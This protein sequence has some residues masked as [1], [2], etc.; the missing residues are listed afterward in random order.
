MKVLVTG[1][2]GFIG[3]HLVERLVQEGHQV[4]C[5]AK[6]RLHSVFLESLGI[7]LMLGDLNNGMDLEA[8]L[9]GVE[10][11]YHLA[12]V[13]RARVNR[14]YYEGNYLATKKFIEICARSSNKIKR[15][16]HV[17]SQA[18]MGPAVN[19]DPVTE[20]DV[21]HPVS[22]YGKS[23]MLAEKE[24]LRYRDKIP[25]TIVR[26]SAVYGPRDKEMLQYFLLIKK[27]LQPLIGFGKKWLNFVYVDDLVSGLLLAGKHSKAEGESF[28]IGSDTSCTNEE[29]GNIVASILNSKLIRIRIPHWLVFSV[30][31]VAEGAGKLSGKP[32]FFNVQKAREA[33]QTGW[34]FSVAK[35]RSRLGF[36][37]RFSL[38]EGMK[39]TYQWYRQNGWL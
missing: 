35:A 33:V 1:G 36:A 8:M 20:E 38:L 15:F 30:A 23:K 14:D 18:A 10:C 13:T 9:D 17:S 5:V 34:I 19:G 6:D 3:S 39:K 26:P 31:A 32:I 7:E 25:I 37:P 21:Y 24:V 2:T 12:G 16:V 22:H 4:R 27:H 28:F 11:I 29:I